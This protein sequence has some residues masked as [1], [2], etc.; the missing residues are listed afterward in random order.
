MIFNFPFKCGFSIITLP[1][2]NAGTRDLIVR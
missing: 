1:S 2:D